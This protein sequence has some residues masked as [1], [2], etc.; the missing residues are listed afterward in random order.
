MIRRTTATL[1]LLAALAGCGANDPEPEGGTATMDA[2]TQEHTHDLALIRVFDAPAERV[3]QAWTD[4]EQVKQWW[5]PHGF[6]APIA[7]MDVREG[8]TSFVCMQAPPEHGGQLLCNTWSYH[9]VE[10]N[11]RLA[12]VL[13]FT[14]EHGNWIDPAEAGLPAGI[15]NE[16]PH[17]IALRALEDGRTEMTVEEYGYTTEQARELSKAGLEQ[18]L[19]KMAALLAGS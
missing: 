9:T 16:V 5:G 12:F 18:T 10:P 6:T 7:E 8:G 19:D 3:W 1:V 14:D 13:R 4:A 17:V 15:P 11:R 2:S